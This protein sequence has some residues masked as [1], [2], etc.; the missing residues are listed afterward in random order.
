[1][2]ALTVAD[3]RCLT[4]IAPPSEKAR[5][6]VNTQSIAEVDEVPAQEIAPPY[7]AVF[8]KKLQFETVT[9]ICPETEMAP[10]D[11]A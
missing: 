7:V 10:P 6:S 8:E 5:F 9:A 1:V 3:A 4:E 2:E 11:E